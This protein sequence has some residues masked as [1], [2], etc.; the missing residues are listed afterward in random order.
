MLG[1]S[2]KTILFIAVIALFTTPLAV[3]YFPDADAIKSKGTSSKYSLKTRAMVC[4][5]QLCIATPDKISMQP[6]DSKPTAKETKTKI[7]TQSEIIKTRIGTLELQSDYLTPETAKTLK[8]ELFFQR[9]IQVYQLAYPA[10]A[11]AGIFYEQD[12]VGATTGDILYWS[13]FM[14][15]DIEVLTGNISVLYYMSLQDLSDGPIVMDVPA[16]SLQGHIDNIYQQVITD[17]GGTGPYKGKGGQILILPPNYDGKIPENYVV[18]QSDT[19]QILTVGRA[20]VNAPDMAAAEELIK[21]L[22]IYKLSEIDNSPQVKFFDVSGRSLKLAHPTTDGFWEFLH[23]VYSKET[24]VRPEDKNLIGLMHA[25]GIIPGEP[26][27]PDVHSKELLD[28]AAIVANLMTRNIAYDS[29]VKESFLYYPDKNWEVGFMTKN[30]RFEDERGATEIE[31]R[32]AYTYQAITTSDAMVLE[33]VGKGSKYL[34][35]YRDSDENFLSG[36]NTYHLS[37]PANVPAANFWSV[38]V[39]DAET[40]SMIKNDV[41]SLPGIR[42]LDSDSLRQNSDGSYDVYFGPQI[43]EGY[44]NNWV[45][46]NEG[47]G[48]FVIFRFYSPTEAYYDKSWQLPN[49]ERIQ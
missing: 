35:N 3:N 28:E 38:V 14:N 24:V 29:P 20:F 6:S 17:V 2:T 21:K 23:Q 37:I 10:V 34:M 48:F 46:T 27:V 49:I 36:S 32:L 12:K 1:I 43:P 13:D 8:D 40:R 22:N 16:G 26:F 33:I 18:V 15:S 47:D 25:I 45:K 42:S 19:M 39:Y 30:P 9:A 11:G 41:Q 44:E 7:S 5:D 4:G 31:P